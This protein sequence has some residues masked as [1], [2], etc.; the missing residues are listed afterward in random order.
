MNITLTET[1]QGII[2]TGSVFVF[3]TDNKYKDLESSDDILGGVDDLGGGSGQ[4][5]Q[6]TGKQY[7]GMLEYKKEEESKLVKYLVSGEK[8]TLQ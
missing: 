6:Q 7:M 1:Q 5:K 8:K 2:L 4:I 3:L